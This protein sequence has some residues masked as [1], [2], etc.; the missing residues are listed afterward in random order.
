MFLWE[1]SQNGAFA[2]CLQPHHATFLASVTFS[3]TG[4]YSVGLWEPSQYGCF[5][6]MPH[7]HQ[8]YT[9]GSIFITNGFFTGTLG[10]FIIN[11]FNPN[12][13]FWYF[14]STILKMIRAG[15]LK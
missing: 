11:W 4:L 9:P 5:F 7:E 8:A 10:N 3:I 13:R 14:T 2:E 6:D 12:S 15:F 1:P